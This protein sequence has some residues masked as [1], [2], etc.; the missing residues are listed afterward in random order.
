MDDLDTGS[1]GEVGIV[2]LREG[3]QSGS[4]LSDASRWRRSV[5]TS[6]GT[7][8][9]VAAGTGGPALFLNRRGGRLS[10]QSAWRSCSAPPSGPTSK[11]HVSPHTLRHSFATHLL[12]GGADVRVVQELLVRP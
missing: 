10:R 11:E 12:D 4:C 9:A 8:R 3:W 1:P 7:A 6:C 5:P 2:R